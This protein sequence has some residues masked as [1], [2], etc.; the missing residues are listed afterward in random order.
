MKRREDKNL[1]EGEV[2]G[3]AHRV[4]TDDVVVYGEGEVREMSAPSGAVVT[5]EEHKTVS[6]PPGE[7]SIT[8]QREEQPDGKPGAVRD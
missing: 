8:I 5:H 6:L 1:A 4:I 7:Y 2:T 3:H